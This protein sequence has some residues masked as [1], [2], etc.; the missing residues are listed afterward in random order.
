MP[1]AW[2]FQSVRL[3]FVFV[4][5]RG[6]RS[7]ATDRRFFLLLLELIIITGGGG[8]RLLTIIGTAGGIITDRVLVPRLP[9][10]SRGRL[11]GARCVRRYQPIAT[12]DVVVC[13]R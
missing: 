2:L 12:L 3:G 9:F 6:C 5:T 8:R 7:T 11:P 4:L 10:G 13:D 1:T